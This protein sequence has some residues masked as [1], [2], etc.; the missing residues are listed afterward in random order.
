MSGSLSPSFLLL[1]LL[2]QLP[3]FALEAHIVAAQ[4]RVSVD[5]NSETWA[6]SAGESIGA[7]R[8]VTTGGDGFARL[9]IA[10]GEWIEVYANSRVIFQQ[11]PGNAGDLVDILAGRARVHVNPKLGDPQQRVF[12]RTAIVVAH[13]PATF[14]VAIDEENRVR[15]DVLEGVVGVQHALLPNSEP[16]L[17]RAIDAIVI[18]KDEKISRQMERGTLYRYAVKPFHDLFEALTSGHSAGRVQEQP[19][20]E[21]MAARN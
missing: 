14:A 21:L 12:C 17:V 4:G 19:F 2:I 9:E 1:F 13:E 7:Q 10:D 20:L 15:I 3:A 5:R 16:T 18:E 6:V 8:T 11:N